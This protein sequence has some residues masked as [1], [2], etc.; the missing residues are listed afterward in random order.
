M[1]S[2]SHVA[3]SGD[4]GSWVVRNGKLCGFIISR[5]VGE[6]W[7]YMLPIEQVFEDIHEHLESIWKSEVSIPQTWL[8]GP[9]LNITPENHP[10]VQD[11]DNG[12][13]VHK[14]GERQSKPL[15]DEGSVSARS[16]EKP[17]D[18]AAAQA[19]IRLVPQ[20]SPPGQ[21]STADHQSDHAGPVF[22]K[23]ISV[24]E[25]PS[26]QEGQPSQAKLPDPPLPTY[27]RAPSRFRNPDLP[28]VLL[29]PVRSRI[30]A[31]DNIP[32]GPTAKLVQEPQAAKDSTASKKDGKQSGIKEEQRKEERKE[33][34]MK[35]EPGKEERPKEE[36]LVRH[37]ASPI[38]SL[39]DNLRRTLL[40]RFSYILDPPG[41]INATMPRVSHLLQAGHDIRANK[42]AQDI[43]LEIVVFNDLMSQLLNPVASIDITASKDETQDGWWSDPKWL[44]NLT[45]NASPTKTELILDI[46]SDEIKMIRHVV[47]TEVSLIQYS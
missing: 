11:L 20:P 21:S 19:E 39:D 44:Q 45:I 8:G 43:V 26:P 9:M 42:T 30:V 31:R 33:G 27:V 13:L 3:V 37:E 35:S 1:C 28:P 18:L 47:K 36:R 29:G 25:S 15:Q 23:Q 10:P 7:A 34:S 41:V 6:A 2:C 4:S 38:L 24:Q 5:T 14:N 32:I 12:L 16:D 17:T 46:L 40:P 22:T